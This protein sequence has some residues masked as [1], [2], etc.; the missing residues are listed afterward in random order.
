MYL[1]QESPVYS[2]PKRAKYRITLVISD[3]LL[4]SLDQSTSTDSGLELSGSDSEHSIANPTN[5]TP[6]S[7]PNNVCHPRVGRDLK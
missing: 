3:S 5:I 7:Q 2:Q 4:D 6:S 1:F